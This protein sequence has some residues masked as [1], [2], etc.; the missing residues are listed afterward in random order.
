MAQRTTQ[1]A[2]QALLEQGQSVWL[3]Y[4]RRGMLRSGE[5]QALIDDG[6]RGMTSN[7][8]IFEH[9]IGG[10][11][12]YDDGLRAIAASPKTDLEVFERL[13]VED[14]RDAADLFRPVYDATE[15][16]DGF[17][18]LEVS[19]ALAR[20]T[21]RTIAEAR[22]LWGEVDRPNLMI[23]VPGTREGW[24]AIQ[25]LLTDGVNVNITLLFSLEHYRQVALAYLRALETR[26]RL[27]QPID[28]LASVASFFVSRVDTETDRRIEVSAPELRDLR[29]K[30]AVANAQLAYVWFR[31]MLKG[32]EWARLAAIGARP[33]RLLWASTGTKN[34][35]YSDVLYVDSLI[36]PDTIN[37]LP[38][39]TLQ[40]FE[41]H[42]HVRTTLSEDGREA[43]AVMDR[44]AAGGVDFADVTRALEEDGIEKF[45]KSFDA[46]LGVI[47]TK[48]QELIA[49]APPAHSAV[50]RVVDAAIAVRLD[51]MEQL[52]VPKRIWARDPTV[53]KTDPD[54]PEIRNRLGWLVVGKAM[55]QQV[56][57]LSRPGR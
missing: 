46:L 17:V 24:P 55:A 51:E 15:G 38:P 5:L 40:L 19:P 56:K 26:A 3:D 4:L 45:A 41:D 18:S 8:T 14:V 32:P 29:G 31:A 47:K 20:D 48:R 11:S 44:L 28:R 53:W 9:A 13:A 30:V 43:A 6:L 23:K 57:T 39:A 33:Q 35:G 16:R 37:T 22:R 12:D 34:P 1:T 7:P 2:M 25:R 42:G 36:G 50:F 10:S 54:T 52:H 27:G 21:E 49:H